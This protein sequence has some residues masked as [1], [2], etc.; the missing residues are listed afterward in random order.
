[1]IGVEIINVRSLRESVP[2]RAP[3]RAN[4]ARALLRWDAQPQIGAR[5]RWTG[6]TIATECL[7]IGRQSDRVQHAFDPSAATQGS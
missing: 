3:A 1:M 5:F 4:D 7:V 2:R 6:R